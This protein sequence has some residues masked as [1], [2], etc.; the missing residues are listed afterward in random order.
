MFRAGEEDEGGSNGGLGLERQE[1]GPMRCSAE[2]G[3]RE[4]G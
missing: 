2:A 3:R 4:V 1:V